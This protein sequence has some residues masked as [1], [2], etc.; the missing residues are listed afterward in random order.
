[1]DESQLLVEKVADDFFEAFKKFGQILSGMPTNTTPFF[2]LIMCIVNATLK[3]RNYLG[4]GYRKSPT[5]LAWSCRNLLELNV[6][7][8]YSL[9]TSEHWRHFPDD[10]WLDGIDIFRSFKAFLQHF[11][12]AVLTPAIDQTIA[13]FEGEISKAGI[14]RTKYLSV[15][16]L[17]KEPGMPDHMAAEYEHMGKLTSKLVHPT[18]FSVLAFEMQGE[19]AEIPKLMFSAGARYTMAIYQRIREHVDAKGMEP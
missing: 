12:P 13:N 14:T 1:M 6:I 19:L 4:I 17:S 8:H 11:D 15:S 7:T 5:L 18:A 10:M 2:N 16:R 9:L 3:Q